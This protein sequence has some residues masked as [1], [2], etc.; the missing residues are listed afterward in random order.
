MSITHVR[1]QRDSF[2]AT[3]ATLYSW[4]T[5]SGREEKKKI[6][7]RTP[8]MKQKMFSIRCWLWCNSTTQSNLTNFL[9]H[10]KEKDKKNK[11]KRK[12]CLL[13]IAL[14][15]SICYA[16]SKTAN[17]NDNDDKVDGEGEKKLFF[18]QE[19][20]L[21]LQSF[22]LWCRSKSFRLFFV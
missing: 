14:F 16:N 8:N 4:S 6:N 13:W 3:A 5:H 19:R 20:F 2:G 12:I 21:L 15:Y 9:R 1:I 11:R 18:S 10:E 17:G 7:S 22:S